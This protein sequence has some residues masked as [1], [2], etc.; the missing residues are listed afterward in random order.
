[1]IPLLTSERNLQTACEPTGPTQWSG[2]SRRSKKGH[3]FHCSHKSQL[4]RPSIPKT[5][6]A[7]DPRAI[8]DQLVLRDAARNAHRPRHDLKSTQPKIAPLQFDRQAPPRNIFPNRLNNR[9]FP[10]GAG[11]GWGLG[12]DG[13]GRL[14]LGGCGFCIS[15]RFPARRGGVYICNSRM[16]KRR[17]IGYSGNMSTRI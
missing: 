16:V 14:I 4:N 10:W 9:N 13:W 8:N 7:Q 1:M 12:E 17:C 3:H 15:A 5:C 2:R 11:R 6:A